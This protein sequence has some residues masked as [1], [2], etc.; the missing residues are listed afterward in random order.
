M[1]IWLKYP[2][3]FYESLMPLSIFMWY[4]NPF[5]LPWYF[6]HF[7]L[8]I[9]YCGWV[10]RMWYFRSLKQRIV[11]MHLV[12]GG[13]FVKFETHTLSSDINFAW[14]ENYNFHPLTED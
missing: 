3:V 10:P 5:D 8:F 9:A 14:T 13:K 11:K 2:Y 1:V 7:N 6:N 12:R 4:A